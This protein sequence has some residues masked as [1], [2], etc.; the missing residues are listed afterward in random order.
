M[1]NRKQAIG[2]TLAV[3]L[4]GVYSGLI[5]YAVVIVFGA[6]G[7]TP[8]SFTA[9]M[10]WALTII[11]G[12]VAVLVITELAVTP[13]GDSPAVH[14]FA[15]APAANQAPPGAVAKWVNWIYL[16]IWVATGLTAF[17]AGALLH[18]DV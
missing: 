9:E 6:G 3:I 8:G 15:P 17:V 13:P 4:L 18:A 16:L 7:L 11:S 10:K 5:V 2:G 1:N 14:M 12:L